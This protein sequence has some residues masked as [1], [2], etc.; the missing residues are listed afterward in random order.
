[1]DSFEEIVAGIVRTVVREELERHFGKVEAPA[2][3][4]TINE[5]A[6]AL[7][8]STRTVRRM[9]AAGQLPAVHAGR[10]VRI[11]R[12][13]LAALA[14]GGDGTASARSSRKRSS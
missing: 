4:V 1:M 11:P 10:A 12:A 3:V 7:M 13:A 2:V 6:V 5:A 9:I 8:M 14:A